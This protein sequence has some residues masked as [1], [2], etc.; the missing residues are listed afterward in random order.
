MAKK[1]DQPPQGLG[2][3]GGAFWL[4]LTDVLEFSPQETEVLMEACRTLD[5]IDD[6][7]AAIDTD[8]TVVKGSM[9]QKVLH[10]AVAEVRQLQASFVR[11]TD[12]LHLPEDV[13]AKDKF[14]TARAKAGA[15]ALHGLRA[16]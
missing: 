5:R 11:L 1:K 9:G 12:A 13:E 14:R 10:P 15:A 2:D 16:V 6:L 8:G 7:T 4:A 3:R